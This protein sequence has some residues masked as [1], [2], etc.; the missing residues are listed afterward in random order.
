MTET[1]LRNAIRDAVNATGKAWLCVNAR[2]YRGRV[3]LGLM[4]NSSADLVG[5]LT[6]SGRYVGIECKSPD[7]KSQTGKLSEAQLEWARRVRLVGGFVARVRSVDEALAAIERAK[8]GH[9]Q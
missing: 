5:M 7:N 1:I 3:P 6:G 9:S 2:G 4:P 8:E